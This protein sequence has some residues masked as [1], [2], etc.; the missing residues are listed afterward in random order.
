MARHYSGVVRYSAVVS[1]RG[2]PPALRRRTMTDRNGGATAPSK[3]P[4]V[5]P[6]VIHIDGFAARLGSEGYTP[7][8]MHDK[9]ELLAGLSP[10]PDRL[11]LSPGALHQGVL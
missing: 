7:G 8:S 6:L 11:A 9:C 10:W 4:C 1:E 3:R 5:G 2:F